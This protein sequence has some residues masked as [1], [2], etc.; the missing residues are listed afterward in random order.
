MTVTTIIAI[1]LS[2]SI[3]ATL[4]VCHEINKGRVKAQ[5]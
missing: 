5:S 2:L 3:I 4:W 1:E